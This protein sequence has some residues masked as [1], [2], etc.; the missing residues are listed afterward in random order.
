MITDTPSL[1][2]A[3]CNEIKSSF[4]NKNQKLKKNTAALAMSLS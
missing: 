1:K 2:T 3:Y 4:Q